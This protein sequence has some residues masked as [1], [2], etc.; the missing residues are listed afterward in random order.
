MKRYDNGEL[1]TK[2]RME[3]E[4]WY[5]SLY[6]PFLEFMMSFYKRRDVSVEEVFEGYKD[7]YL[8][9]DGEKFPNQE[10]DRLLRWSVLHCERHN[11]MPSIEEIEK[12]FKNENKN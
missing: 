3:D 8:Q 10:E 11:S 7:F 1:I 5:Y 2:Q 6:Q 12:N 9:L 4:E